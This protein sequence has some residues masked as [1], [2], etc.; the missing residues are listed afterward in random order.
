MIKTALFAAAAAIA[1][2]ATAAPALAK[3]MPVFYGD[4][5]LASTKGQTTLSHR[6]HRAAK[7]ACNFNGEGRVPS[8]AAMTCY[9]QAKASARTEMAALVEDTRLGG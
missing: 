4:L 7:Q 1:T 8:H 6:I 5:D 2:V 3:D 9:K